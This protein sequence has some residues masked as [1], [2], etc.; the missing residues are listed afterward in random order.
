MILSPEDSY[1]PP[2][3]DPPWQKT[4]YQH[5]FSG[6]KLFE[7]IPPRFRTA[8]ACEMFEDEDGA[9]GGGGGHCHKSPEEAEKEDGAESIE[10]IAADVRAG[11]F[12]AWPESY[13]HRVWTFEPTLAA[14]GY[15]D[16]ARRRGKR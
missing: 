5:L 13:V 15:F 4:T 6:R 3:F 1:T 11:D 2:H 12:V 9:G 16:P 14:N 8:L 7:M 10:I